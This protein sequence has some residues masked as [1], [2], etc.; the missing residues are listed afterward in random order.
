MSGA[1]E[2]FEDVV[3]LFA[4]P[5]FRYCLREVGDPALAED[6]VQETF[7]RTYRT[8]M[9]GRPDDVAA[10]LF[11]VARNVCREEHRRKPDPLAAEPASKA[12]AE[13][14]QLSAAMESLDDAERSLLHLKHAEGRSCREIAEM[15]GKPLGTVTAALARAYRK[16]RERMQ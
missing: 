6:L 14:E 15:L 4:A 2:E 9:N 11:G 5:L 3:R 1:P 7:L 16:L 8:M 10:W 12:P 13:H